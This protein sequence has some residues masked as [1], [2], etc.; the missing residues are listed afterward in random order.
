MKM[1]TNLCRV[2]RCALVGFSLA[3]AGCGFQLRTPAEIPFNAVYL[4]SSMAS[5]VMT[6]LRRELAAPRQRVTS[7]LSGADAHIRI[8][9]E[10]REKVIFTL[11]GT[12]RVREYQLRMRVIYSVADGR[13]K[14][15]IEP[16]E[17][18]V[19]RLISYDDRALAAKEQEEQFLYRD[20]QTEVTQQILRRLSVV[21]VARG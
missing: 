7:Q 2:S 20:M 19:T 3:L 10:D 12:G 9:R 11:S 17:I 13:D 5:G 18:I 21:G 4:S 8:A 14:T 16:A 6:E 1:M 15:L